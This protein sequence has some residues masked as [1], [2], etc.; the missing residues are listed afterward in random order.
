MTNDGT[1]A[2]NGVVVR[3][4]LPAGSRYI[5]A[6]NLTNQFLCTETQTGIV[7][8]V[9]GQVARRP[10]NRHDHA[11]DVRARHAG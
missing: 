5:Q 8:C 10:R 4:K 1:D 3:D 11:E 9:N 2:V 7:D 6:N